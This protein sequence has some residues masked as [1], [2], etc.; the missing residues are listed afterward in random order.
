MLKNEQEYNVL[1]KMLDK[2]ENKNLI[3]DYLLKI[4]KNKLNLKNEYQQLNFNNFIY[5]KTCSLNH[6][7]KTCS[8]LNTFNIGMIINNNNF[9]ENLLI[10]FLLNKSK[11]DN[12]KDLFLFLKI[13][14]KEE[15]LIKLKE[16]YSL[17]NILEKQKNINFVFTDIK[18]NLTNDELTSIFRNENLEKDFVEKFMKKYTNQDG[19]TKNYKF[20]SEIKQINEEQIKIFFENIYI[21][22]EFLKKYAQILV[23]YDIKLENNKKLNEKIIE[24][25]ID[26]RNYNKLKNSVEVSKNFIKKN[27]E[28]LTFGFIFN[29][30]TDIEDTKY[31]LDLL[32]TMQCKLLRSG[33]KMN[34]RTILYRLLTTI[35]LSNNKIDFDFYEE[36][37]NKYKINYSIKEKIKFFNKNTSSKHF[38]ILEKEFKEVKNPEEIKFYS[39]NYD[40]DIFKHLIVNTNIPDDFIIKYF[41]YLTYNVKESNLFELIEKQI[42]PDKLRNKDFYKK[43]NLSS[44]FIYLEQIKNTKELKDMSSQLNMLQIKTGD[45]ILMKNINY[46]KNLKHKDLNNLIE[47][48]N[49][50]Y[51][52]N[53]DIE[54]NRGLINLSVCLSY[55]NEL[56]TKNEQKKQQDFGLS[57]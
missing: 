7:K 35:N 24:N 47:N 51:T 32:Y 19:L 40:Y 52:K 48:I 57:Y 39:S 3:N 45:F 21:D 31:F 37:F 33:S 1:K 2:I 17:S 38:S 8:M 18:R 29:K 15:N 46:L 6:L 4:Y 11:E 26:I 10:D 50:M 9:D 25:F 42:I 13:N 41:P 34:E 28:H 5:V 27:I 23:E 12:F 14:L 30:I 55:N 22:E 20:N 36:M 49:M 16:N 44:I 53:S 54:L 56:I 43:L